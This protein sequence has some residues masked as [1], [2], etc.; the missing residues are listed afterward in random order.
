MS[1]SD[2]RTVVSPVRSDNL[3]GALCLLVSGLLALTLS[4]TDWVHAEDLYSGEY[5]A[6]INMVIG[7][8]PAEAM[9]AAPLFVELL[10]HESIAVLTDQKLGQTERRERLRQI[11]YRSF[12]TTDIAHAVLGRYWFMATEDEKGE[13]MDVLGRYVA[14][15]VLDN[16]S[17]GQF[18]IFSTSQVDGPGRGGA[19]YGVETVLSADSYSAQVVWTIG[20]VDGEPKVLDLVIAGNSFLL[21]Q[22][23]RFASILRRNDGSVAALIEAIRPAS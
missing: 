7:D 15:T 19:V 6:A 11:F 23:D 20:I 16:F 14:T 8:D 10:A 3:T 13:F 5:D 4:I 2:T 22:R 1:L 18:E 17:S 9:S 12:A 21:S